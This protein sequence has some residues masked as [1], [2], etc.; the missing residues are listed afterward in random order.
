MNIPPTEAVFG[1][2]KAKFLATV[3]DVVHRHKVLPQLIINWG[4]T[5]LNIVPVLT[6]TMKE[7]VALEFLL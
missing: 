1:E 5:G 6:W 4:Q 7:N 3:Q 2:V